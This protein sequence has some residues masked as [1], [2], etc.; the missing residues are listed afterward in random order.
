[1]SSKTTLQ[2]TAL[3]LVD[4]TQFIHVDFW[5][6]EAERLGLCH[7]SLF[8]ADLLMRQSMGPAT[9]ISGCSDAVLCEQDLHFPAEDIPK[10]LLVV[11][12]QG[13]VSERGKYPFV[14]LGPA[15]R[16]GRCSPS[17][18]YSL[19]TDRFTWG[20]FPRLPDWLSA[21]YTVNCNVDDPRIHLLPF[22][23]NTDGHGASI[24]ANY[25]KGPDKKDG[26]FYANFQRNSNRRV[27][28]KEVFAQKPWITYEHLPNIPVEKYLEE[29]SSH[30]FVACPI[31]NGYDQY[32]IYETLYLGS[33]PVV[34]DSVWARKLQA[35]RIPLL[36]VNDMTRLTPDFLMGFW[37]E[38]QTYPWSYQWLIASCWAHQFQKMSKTA[39]D[40]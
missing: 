9:V 12:W 25:Q 11:N 38:A 34:E 15:V 3:Q 39:I 33:I 10:Y 29:V 27:A 22:G 17:D 32:R 18:F 36:V 1:M 14:Q 26:L 37:R 2:E 20:T 21:W 7:C 40:K 6:K 30:K 8:D 31:G 5:Q 24:L 19:K 35:T 13:L 23:L 28:I 4:P 16:E